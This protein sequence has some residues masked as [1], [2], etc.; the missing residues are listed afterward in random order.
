M[1]QVTRLLRF[2]LLVL[3]AVAPIAAAFAAVQIRLGIAD[4]AGEG[5]SAEQILL[6][7][8]Y[9]A[10]RPSM[11]LTVGRLDL[12]GWSVPF[13]A[14]ELNCS[15]IESAPGKLECRSEAAQLVVGPGAARRTLNPLIGVTLDWSAGTIAEIQIDTGLLGVDSLAALLPETLSRGLSE[16]VTFTA[17]GLSSH[18]AISVA[19]NSATRIAGSARFQSFAFSDP[20]GTRAG[21]N[22]SARLEFDSDLS[23]D[24]LTFRISSEVIGGD[25]FIN[26][27]FFSWANSTPQFSLNGHWSKVQRQLNLN[28]SYQHPGQLDLVGGAEL[29]GIDDTVQVSSAFGRLQ[30]EDLAASYRTYLQP[31]LTGTLGGDLEAS[32]HLGARFSYQ[33]GRGITSLGLQFKEVSL[34]DRPGRFAI[35]GLSASLPW[36]GVDNPSSG[37]IN[38]QSLQLYRLPFGCGSSELRFDHRELELQISPVALFDGGF[39][40]GSVV[41]QGLGT[42]ELSVSMGGEISP[43]SL[44]L[45]TAALGWPKM[46]GTLAA[47]VPAI[48]YQSGRLRLDGGLQLNVFDGQL[49][50][51]HLEIENLF[52]LVPRLS[53]GLIA[54]NLDLALITQTFDFGNITG[55][56]SGEVVGLELESWQPVAFDGWLQTPT[57]DPGSHRISQRALDSLSSIGGISGALQSTL[58]RFFD[59]FSYRRLGIGCRLIHGV[60]RMRGIADRGSES[61]GGYYIIQGGGLWPRIDLVGHNRQVDWPVLLQRLSAAANVDR[62]EIR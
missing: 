38:W 28:G 35:T 47:K 12:A 50:V 7:I 62:V 42:D 57:G 34:V 54:E 40:G 46:A 31:L 21:E 2:W 27:L 49:A 4:A 48:H 37:D 55:R 18:V 15:S 41:L 10:Q 44:P 22:L 32:G 45:I 3:L 29:V 59:D 39:A 51:S 13:R 17:G 52:G 33:Q 53:T 11:K 30:V 9:S 19:D 1:I 20:M 8:E 26:P 25:L 56:V 61:A 6:A 23:P 60:C 58:L 43:V 24:E 16:A 14:L 5:W 36:R